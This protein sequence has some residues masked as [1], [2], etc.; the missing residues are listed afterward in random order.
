VDYPIADLLHMVG[1]AGRPAVDAHGAAL[2]QCHGPRAEAL[3]RLLLEPLPVESHLDHFLHDH[4][5]A[6]VVTRTVENKQDAVDY[7][8]WTL[9]WPRLAHNPNYY[10]LQGTSHRHLSD[11]LSELVEGVITDLEESRALAVEGDVHLA[12]LNLGMIAAYYY[13]AYTTVELFASSLTDKTKLRGL[14]EI[15]C[16][17]SECGDLPVR[18]HDAQLLQQLVNHLPQKLPDAAKFSDPHTKALVLLQAHFSRHPLSAELASDQ[19]VVLGHS[20]KLLQALVDVI[21]SNGWLKPAIVAMECSQMIVQGLWDKDHPLLQLPHVD[22]DTLGRCQAANNARLPQDGSGDVETVFDVMA[23][24]DEVRDD[25][26]RLSAGETRD[27]AAFCNAYPN[28]ELSFEVVDADQVET[29]DAVTVVVTLEREADD[30]GDDAAGAAAAAVVYAPKYPKV[31]HE[32]W[33]LVVGNAKTNALL[34]VKRVALNSKAT[35]KLD[36][37]APDEPG[38]YALTLY[39]MCDSYIG[40]DQEYALELKVAQGDSDEDEDEDGGEEKDLEEEEA[41]GDEGPGM[42]N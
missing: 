42:K 17:A 15:V 4:L 16:A 31:K 30:D 10:N 12:P 13:I 32:G 18:H 34:C 8:T 25:L 40:C 41:S 6:E 36:F 20:L 7:M 28:V 5:N 2:V 33:W 37:V 1:R 11:H 38:D 24:D 39:F 35:V 9:Y 23:L 14:L 21:S 3:R 29:G 27:V 22:K 19:A 26:L